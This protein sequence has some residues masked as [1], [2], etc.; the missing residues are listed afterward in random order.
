MF[1]A[2]YLDGGS[3][4]LEGTSCLSPWVGK[5]CCQAQALPLPADAEHPLGRCWQ[6]L[7]RAL[8]SALL[9]STALPALCSSRPSRAE[10]M[11]V[12][13]FASFVLSWLQC[14]LLQGAWGRGRCECMHVRVCV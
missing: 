13:T 6:P 1:L 9:G 2:R 3:G 10:H 5:C 7:S 14:S 4:S 11:V 12:P 8:S